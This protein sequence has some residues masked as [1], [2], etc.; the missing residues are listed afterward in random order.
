MRAELE[1]GTDGFWYACVC[2]ETRVPENC[3][4][5]K[6][7]TKHLLPLPRSASRAEAENVFRNF[8]SREVR[9]NERR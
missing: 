1:R 2:D 8:V 4:V 3:G 5:G 7:R 9:R 6:V